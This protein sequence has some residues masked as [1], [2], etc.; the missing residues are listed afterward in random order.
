MSMYF[1]RWPINFIITE[2]GIH[3]SCDHAHLQRGSHTKNYLIKDQVSPEYFWGLIHQ[4]TRPRINPRPRHGYPG[5]YLGALDISRDLYCLVPD[6]EPHSSTGGPQK[7]FS[8]ALTA[9]SHTKNLRTVLGG[10]VHN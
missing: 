4:G 8:M 10:L 9:W 2:Y 5:T 6:Q 1:S 3:P 7:G